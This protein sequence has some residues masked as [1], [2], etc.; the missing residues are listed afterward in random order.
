MSAT[1]S[2]W[3]QR[4]NALEIPILN[5]SAAYFQKHQNSPATSVGTLLKCL[6]YDP[7]FSLNL[8][9]AAGHSRRT[10][11]KTVSH[12]MLLLGLPHVLKRPENL[13]RIEAHPNPVCRQLLQRFCARSFHTVSYATAWLNHKK[14]LH[15]AELL[16][17]CQNSYFIEYL[18]CLEEPDAMLKLLQFRG[19]AIAKQKHEQQ[20]FGVC[21]QELALEISQDWRLP[22]LLIQINDKSSHSANKVRLVQLARAVTDE[23]M[24]SWYG[25]S[26]N[27]LIEELADYL[28]LSKDETCKELH[29]G[30]ARIAR[31]SI[32]HYPAGN[33]AAAQLVQYMAAP[34]KIKKTTPEKPDRNAILKDALQ[35][36]STQADLNLQSCIEISFKALQ[37][38]LL[39]E[40]IFFAL[41]DK[42]KQSLQVRF[43]I[44]HQQQEDALNGVRF[45][46]EK[47]LFGRLMNKPAAVWVKPENLKQY[48]PLIRFR[49]KQIASAQSFFAMS[50]FIN[51]KPIG[52]LFG[53]RN[54]GRGLT[55]NEFKY[56]KKIC[57]S[58][59]LAIE[60]TSHKQSLQAEKKV[61]NL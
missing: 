1:L 36:L 15:N 3:K 47:N 43:A 40:D 19:T 35:A 7:G 18:M 34:V 61:A 20:L 46:L 53:N 55:E 58:V 2:E 16:T 30:S 25:R 49:Q 44:N 9:R 17:A 29:R 24:I 39:L 22:E 6:H 13:P 37:Q 59:S 28:H 26:M 31:Q 56:F 50:V 11:V 23:S 33:S 45:S 32:Q 42:D 10:R 57:K 52:L 41:L 60:R 14:E 12:A 21:L 4:I 27:S 5:A 48:R 54:S 51:E 8:L 38:A